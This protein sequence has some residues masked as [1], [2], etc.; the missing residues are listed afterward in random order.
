MNRTSNYIIKNLK[1][2]LSLLY[3]GSS[4]F[5]VADIPRASELSAL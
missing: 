3:G 5:N 1:M 4:V 2:N